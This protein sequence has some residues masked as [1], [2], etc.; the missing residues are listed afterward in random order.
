MNSKTPLNNGRIEPLGVN[1]STESKDVPE[2]SE[3][4][5][6][7]VFCSDSTSFAHWKKVELS[8]KEAQL[9]LEVFE[10]LLLPFYPYLSGLH[11]PNQARHLLNEH[12]FTWWLDRESIKA[13][14]VVLP[15]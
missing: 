8:W 15:V 2:A 5:I 4:V 6:F 11:S 3:R 14:N 7:S 13:L 12:G 1:F 10:E 9:I